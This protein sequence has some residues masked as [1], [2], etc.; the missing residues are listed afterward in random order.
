MLRLRFRGLW[1]D[2]VYVLNKSHWL[3]TLSASHLDRLGSYHPEAALPTDRSAL[4]FFHEFGIYKPPVDASHDKI[5]LTLHGGFG[6]SCRGTE[7][8]D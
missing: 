4:R 7:Q 8:G 2:V 1:F 5:R 3:L 6:S